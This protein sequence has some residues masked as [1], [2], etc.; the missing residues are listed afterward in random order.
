MYQ[1][2]N[3]RDPSKPHRWMYGGCASWAIAFWEQAPGRHFLIE[4]EWDEEIGAEMLQHVRVHDKQY[5]WDA[6]GRE[7]LSEV[8][9]GVRY[10]TL[11]E[12]LLW[13]E[14][15]ARFYGCG[16]IDRDSIDDAR[17]WIARHYNSEKPRQHIH[18][19]VS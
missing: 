13:N 6:I 14:E 11:G 17:W 18:P 9:G 7:P 15:L 3:Q 5:A 2:C 8:H 12:L 4:T 19:L 1:V 10:A 16:I